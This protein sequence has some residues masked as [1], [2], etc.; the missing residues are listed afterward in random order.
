[1]ARVIATESTK[2]KVLTQ[3]PSR[4]TLNTQMVLRGSAILRYLRAS[5]FHLR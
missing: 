2:R 4:C 5:A 3:I 1:M